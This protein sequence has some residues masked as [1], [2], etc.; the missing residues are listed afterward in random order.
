MPLPGTAARPN[1]LSVASPPLVPQLDTFTSI[2]GLGGNAASI[3]G[4][5]GSFQT[6][7]A[8]P[9][10]AGITFTF[11]FNLARERVRGAE[12]PP[13]YQALILLAMLI[14]SFALHMLY[15]PAG[16]CCFVAL[17]LC[18]NELLMPPK[19]VA[20]PPDITARMAKE[21]AKG[22]AKKE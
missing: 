7:T 14:A 3:L 16:L 5:Y 10:L 15:L 18:Q 9:A 13:P 8:W 19:R 4:M 21:A 6:R 22:A 1:A 17:L 20:T 12:K 11:L 2:S